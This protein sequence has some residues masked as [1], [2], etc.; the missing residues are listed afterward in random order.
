M[1]ISARLFSRAAV[2]VRASQAHTPGRGGVRAQLVS[3]EQ[4]GRRALFLEQLAHQL[5]RRPTVASAVNQHV[6]SLAFVVDTP[7]IRMLADD[8]LGLTSGLFDYIVTK[9]QWGY[10]ARADNAQPYTCCFHTRLAVT[11]ARDR[12]E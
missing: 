7:Q 11:C 1:R 3:R 9:P 5:Q 4:F 12:R 2:F 6:E 10:F 8:P